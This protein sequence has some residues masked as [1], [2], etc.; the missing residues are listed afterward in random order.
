LW[1]N[2]SKPGEADVVATLESKGVDYV[3]WPAWL[4]I[5]ANERSLGEAEGRE[6]IKLF[7]R[8]QMVA[9]SKGE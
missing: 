1:W 5:D 2:P 7:D 3:G 4:K 8:S 9:I 6:R